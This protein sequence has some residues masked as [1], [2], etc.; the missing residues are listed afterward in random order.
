[1]TTTN[2]STSSL[3]NL[4]THQALQ[5]AQLASMAAP[6]LYILSSLVFRRNP[7]KPFS[8]RRLMTV[9]TGSVL[10]GGTAGAAAGWA[11]NKDANE[12]VNIAKVAKMVCMITIIVI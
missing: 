3:N 6:P 11:L 8:I 1:M 12:V 7:L 4:I 9:S 2:P 10:A 5:G